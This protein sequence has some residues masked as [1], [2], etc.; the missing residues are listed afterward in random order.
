MGRHAENLLQIILFCTKRA[1]SQFYIVFVCY[2]NNIVLKTFLPIRRATCRYVSQGENACTKNGK[3]S[4]KIHRR[5]AIV[6]LQQSTCNPT[7]LRSV[8]SIAA[9]NELQKLK[10]VPARLHLLWKPSYRCVTKKWNTFHGL[11][12]RTQPKV[13]KFNRLAACCIKD[14]SLSS[15]DKVGTFFYICHFALAL[16]LALPSVCSLRLFNKNGIETHDH[17]IVARYPNPLRD[18]A[19]TLRLPSQPDL[20]LYQTWNAE[21]HFRILA[22]SNMVV[23]KPPAEA[24]V[25]AVHLAGDSK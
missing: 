19:A 11:G 8:L 25:H 18:H 16:F 6:T 13:L 17:T 22:G 7:T 23:Q 1:S 3:T 14:V 2:H 4:K 21:L 9:R 24:S 15:Q 20:H 5:V 10:A 12:M